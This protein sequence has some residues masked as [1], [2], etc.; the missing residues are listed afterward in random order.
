MRGKI[1]MS[2]RTIKVDLLEI[3][4]RTDVLRFNFENNPLDVN[5]NVSTCQNE[6]K[7]VFVQL[8]HELL[9]QDYIILEFNCDEKYKRGMYKEVCEEYIKD[10]NR[11]IQKTKEIFDKE[12]NTNSI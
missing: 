7:K 5:L 6:L 2:Q 9:M 12:L 11:E 10:L 8:L 3:D 4:E 1:S